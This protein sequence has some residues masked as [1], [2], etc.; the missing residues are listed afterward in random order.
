VGLVVEQVHLTPGA[1]GAE[2]TAQFV[3]KH[4]P[5]GVVGEGFCDYCSGDRCLHSGSPG[6]PVARS[7]ASWSTY[8]SG[9]FQG[10][11]YTVNMRKLSERTYYSYRCGVYPAN[12]TQDEPM[13]LS[14][15]YS[16]R[17]APPSRPWETPDVVRA[18]TWG[19]MGAPGQ[20]TK[21]MG[22]DSQ[23]TI[24]ALEAD[25]LAGGYELA[26]NVGDS[27]YADDY[28]SGNSWVEDKWYNA[29]QGIMAN[30]PTAVVVGNHEAQYDFAPHLHR[31]SMPVRGKGDLKRFYSSL[32][33]GPLH[34]VAFSSEHPYDEGS[35][36]H[37]FVVNDLLR[38]DRSLTPF[39][40]VVAHRPMYCSSGIFSLP[41]FFTHRC[42]KEAPLLRKPFE[43]VFKE[44]GVDLFLSGHNHQF[45]RSHP[46]YKGKAV[47]RGERRGSKT[48][49]RNPGA[50]IYIVNGA[51]GN[52]EGN[53]PTWLPE[54][55]VKWRASHSA[56]FHIGYGRIQAT[57]SRLDWEY[58]DATSGTVT[59][60]FTL[61]RGNEP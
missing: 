24:D 51:A 16:F 18:V 34:I 41:G 45:E 2:V 12:L 23:E 50:P 20:G 8:A 27:S 60:S 40:I 38:V 17:T 39:V 28:S 58:I 42:I 44:T 4:Q 9:G 59:D 30:A 61:V 29:M 25:V 36:Q 7:R 55:L 19:D 13:A 37:E 46:M 49:Y 35:E 15:I 1:S 14:E 5:P 31:T 56:H 54:W 48:V 33:W 21:W 11:I 6:Q 10:S 26:I 53:D 52:R 43:K 22:M 32:N 47:T 3:V 57:R